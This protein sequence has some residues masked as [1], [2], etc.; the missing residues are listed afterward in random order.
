MLSKILCIAVLSTNF[1]TA[2]A[3]EKEEKN[4]DF[5]HICE[6]EKYTF[7]HYHFEKE[8]QPIYFIKETQGRMQPSKH[9]IKSK[10]FKKNE[11][12]TLVG[13]NDYDL[14]KVKADG[15]YYYV[16]PSS[17]QT[18][19]EKKWNGPV[20]TPSSGTV[21]GPN[22]KETYYNLDMSGVISTMRNMGNND[23]YW[24]RQDGVKMLGDYV[25]VAANLNIHPRGS[26]ISCSLGPAIVCD[27][28]GFASGN[29]NQLD[30]A[31]NW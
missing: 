14:W 25:M 11:K 28:G 8:N 2:P 6:K 29:P 22:G 31:V 21:M 27:T 5:A 23:K 3:V 17:F 9:A 13:K 15:N 20:L 19:L 1:I 30:I 16:D 10:I 24:I 7:Q 4:K 18:E 26:I 12:A